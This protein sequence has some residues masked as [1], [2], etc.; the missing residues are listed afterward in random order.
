MMSEEQTRKSKQSVDAWIKLNESVSRVL[1][2]ELFRNPGK[3]VRFGDVRLAI[4][5]F[6]GFRVSKDVHRRVLADRSLFSWRT[7]C[8]RA[9]W[10]RWK[11]TT[12]TMW[13][14]MWRLW[15]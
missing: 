2:T 11:Y 10:R 14:G 7:C 1:E 5:G 9:R 15:C 13:R 6:D 4:S 8:Y 12:A 3:W